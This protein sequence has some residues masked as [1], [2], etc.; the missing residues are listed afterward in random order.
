MFE[1]LLALQIPFTKLVWGYWAST[2]IYPWI[3]KRCSYPSLLVLAFGLVLQMYRFLNQIGNSLLYDDLR[4]IP[5]SCFN[6]LHNSQ[7]FCVISYG[8]EHWNTWHHLGCCPVTRIFTSA[9]IWLCT[10]STLTSDSIKGGGLGQNTNRFHIYIV[11][12]TSN[13]SYANWPN[14]ACPKWHCDHP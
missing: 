14:P 6:F 10:R 11:I 12:L 5:V 4:I 9:G 13:Q 7:T 2:N 8:R 3:C 1:I